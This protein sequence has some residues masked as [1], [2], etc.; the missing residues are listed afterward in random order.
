M[1]KFQQLLGQPTNE[2]AKRRAK[3]MAEDSQDGYNNLLN[4]RKKEIRGLESKIDAMMD[5]SASPDRNLDNRAVDFDGDKFIN[6]LANI[7]L[8]LETKQLELKVI[9]QRVG[10][11]FKEPEEDAST[12]KN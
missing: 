4:L 12:D 1:N 10:E 8:L 6:E 2:M 5:I 7:E 3:R 9:E 11:Y